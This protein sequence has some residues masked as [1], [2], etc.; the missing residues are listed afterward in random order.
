MINARRPG[1]P[2]DDVGPLRRNTTADENVAGSSRSR[3]RAAV[4]M[5]PDPVQVVLDAANRGDVEA[6][7]DSFADDGVV[8]DWGREFAGRDAIRRWSDAEFIGKQVTLTVTAVDDDGP[9]TVV[10]AE[11]GGNGFNGPSHFSFDVDGPKVTRMTIR[12]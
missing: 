10:N 6:F 7:L 11:V 12:A 4:D 8:D 3:R 1:T 2:D 5:V 9:R